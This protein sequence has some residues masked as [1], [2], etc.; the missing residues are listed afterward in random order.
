MAVATRAAVAAIAL[1]AVVICAGLGQA[2][3]D[4]PGEGMHAEIARELV[5]SG[6]PFA[7]TLAGVRYVDKPPLL[8]VMMAA[9]FTVLGPSEGAARLPSALAALVAVGATAWLGARLLGVGGG[10]LAGVA[11]TTSLGFFAYARYVRPEALLVAVLA[12]GFT[13]A[14]TGIGERRRALVVAG[15]AV[16]GV[17]GL[18]KDPVAAVA[19][20]LAVGLGLLLCRRARP[21]SAWLPVP[22]VAIGL[23]LAVGWWVLAEVRTPGFT[24]YT[25]VDNHLLNVARARHFPDEDVPLGAA[26]F[27]A[28]AAGGA[29]PWIVGALVSIGSLARRRAWRDPSELPW[30]VLAVWTIG[31]LGLTA[32]SPFRLPHYGLP[33][34]PAIAL[35]GARAWVTGRGGSLAA[36]HAAVFAV[37]AL[38]CAAGWASDGRVFFS[39]VMSATDVATRKTGDAAAAGLPP[40]DTL[41]PLLGATALVSA[42]GTVAIVIASLRWRARSL[43]PASALVAVT[44]LAA[45]P[46]VAAALAMVA[47]HRAV[48]PVALEVAARIGAGDTLVHEGPLENS[49]ALEWYAGR[50]PVIV[51][52]R[53]SVLGFGAT[54]PGASA[55]FWERDRL[56]RAWAARER[57]W[58]VTAREPSVSVVKELGGAR[59]VLAAGG[60]RLYVNRDE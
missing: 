59:L 35:L 36:V 42:S 20:P 57:V 8:Y 43:V 25:V 22:G 44:M 54:L 12:T 50:R 40:W 15:L 4:D 24:W 33:A 14:L 5:V 48:R 28:V 39:D 9:A 31:V 1:A 53:R 29:V 30:V 46:I 23:V 41:S 56:G 32:L 38:A 6:D 18:A 60:R 21:V 45:M 19:P 27:L 13:L 16:F 2:P 34:Y 51:D 49:G 26:G 17:A 11:L 10:L 58:L 37:A 7:L 52:G 55:A 47:T 3:F